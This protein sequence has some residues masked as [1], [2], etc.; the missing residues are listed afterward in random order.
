MIDKNYKPWLIEINTNPCLETSSP[1]LV[2]LIP[3]IVENLFRFI[4]SPYII[5]SFHRLV[6]D[7]IFPPPIPWPR[8]KKFTLKD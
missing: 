7:P 3:E 1:L 6:I 4:I 5:D 8:V 2:R